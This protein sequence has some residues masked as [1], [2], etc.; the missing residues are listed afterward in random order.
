MILTGETRNIGNKTYP[1]ATLST[2]KLTWI[3]LESNPALSGEKSAT[4]PGHDVASEGGS[5]SAFLLFI[6]PRFPKELCFEE[7]FRA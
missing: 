1:F 6:A 4:N 2:M 3:D 5:E 7:A